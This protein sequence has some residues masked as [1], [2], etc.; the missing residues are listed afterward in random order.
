MLIDLKKNRVIVEGVNMISKYF[1]LS[2]KN[3]NGGIV[4]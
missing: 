1:K 4:K 2:V 3:I